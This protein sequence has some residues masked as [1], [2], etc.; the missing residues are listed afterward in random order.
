MVFD[1]RVFWLLAYYILIALHAEKERPGLA[2]KLIMASLVGGADGQAAA[3][4]RPNVISLPARA[5][6]TPGHEL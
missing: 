2:K 3:D 5:C 4:L 6:Y 1:I